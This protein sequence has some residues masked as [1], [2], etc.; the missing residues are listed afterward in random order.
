MKELRLFARRTRRAQQLGDRRLTIDDV[1]AETARVRERESDAGP[2]NA[3]ESHDPVER[4]GVDVKDDVIDAESAIIETDDVLGVAGINHA[5]ARV[6]LKE[7]DHLLLQI[8]QAPSLG[9]AV[10]RG[11]REIHRAVDAKRL[12]VVPMTQT[13]FLLYIVNEM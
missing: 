11:E 5:L 13:I 1:L 9:V 4:Q 10:R 2:A 7:A 6:L 3:L 12:E 8:D